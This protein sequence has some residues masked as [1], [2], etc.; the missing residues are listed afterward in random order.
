MVR[1]PVLLAA[2]IGLAAASV[3]IAQTPPK[4]GAQPQTRG[5]P[6]PAGAQAFARPLAALCAAAARISAC[7]AGPAVPRDGTAG[8]QTFLP[9]EVPPH[10]GRLF[11]QSPR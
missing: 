6:V 5:V 8:R 9:T 11:A 7:R 4:P 10:H 1:L 2:S 3:A